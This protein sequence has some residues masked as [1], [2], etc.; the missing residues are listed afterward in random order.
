MSL[1]KVLLAEDEEQ[2]RT[3]MV[4]L[5]EKAGY[6]VLAAGNGRAALDLGSEQIG[7][8]SLVIT[9]LIMPELGGAELVRELRKLRPNLPALC[10]TGYTRDEVQEEEELSGVVFIEKPFAPAVFLD[11]VRELAAQPD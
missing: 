8:I 10:M 7:E 1:E 5:L 3:L 6:A 2:V 4:R 9:D 11:R